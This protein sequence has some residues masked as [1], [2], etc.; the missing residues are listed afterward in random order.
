MIINTCFNFRSFT[1]VAVLITGLGLVTHANADDRYFFLDLNNR[2]AT[3]LF[4]TS[5]FGFTL[6]DINDAGQVVGSFY[7]GSIRHA[8]ITGPNGIGM[9][10]LGTLGG[11]YSAALAINDAGQVVGYS[12]TAEGGSHAFITGPNGMGMRDLG[13]LGGGS[14]AAYGINNIGQVAG[15]SVTNAGSRHA[16]VT[17]PD[18][19]GMRDLDTSGGYWSSADG[20]NDAGQVVGSFYIG[21]ATRHVFLTGP[22][23]TGMRDIGSNHIEPI[24][25]DFDINNAG[26]VVGRGITSQGF[27]HAFITGAD[28]MSI[29]EL[30]SFDRDSGTY[31]S[32][33]AAHSINDAGQAVG[34]SSVHG[35]FFG[36]AFITGPDGGLIDLNSLVDLPE[37]VT[38]TDAM[39]INNNGQIIAVATIPEPETYALMLAGLGLIGFVAWRKKA[40]NRL[41][42]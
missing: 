20:I 36:R 18:G 12:S 40:E 39:A 3:R 4:N 9:R 19:M 1:L 25:D 27:R 24:S 28:G 11:N 14:S 2:T 31:Y 33:S 34:W 22:D 7:R 38:L 23:G 10:D 29:K 17:G 32:M 15:Y 26:Q 42:Y 6:V 8:F 30:S 5:D 13:T 35:S 21:A 16:F 41:G 37:G